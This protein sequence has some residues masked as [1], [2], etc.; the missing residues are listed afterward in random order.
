MIRANGFLTRAASA[1][2]VV[3]QL[4]LAAA[5]PLADATHGPADHE[6]HAH[7][8]AESEAP[9]APAHPIECQL[10]RA[11][12]TTGLPLPAA[13]YVATSRTTHAS[14]LPARTFAPPRSGLRAT[15]GP[16]APPIG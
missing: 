8:E 3:C 9:C 12:A 1:A 5:V 15:L 7:V 16:R 10:A 11:I 13:D 2:C 6:P 14:L 4:L